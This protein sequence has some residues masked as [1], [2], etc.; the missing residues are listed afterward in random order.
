MNEFF[1]AFLITPVWSF[2]KNISLQWQEEDML[3]FQQ[4]EQHNG[5]F[6]SHDRKFWL[7]KQLTGIWRA[8]YAM[9]M[10]QRELSLCISIPQVLQNYNLL[11]GLQKLFPVMGL[12]LKKLCFLPKSLLPIIHMCSP[13]LNLSSRHMFLCSY[14]LAMTN[15]FWILYFIAYNVREQAHFNWKMHHFSFLFSHSFAI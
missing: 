10:F 14:I 5:T 4:T 7:S 13:W 9:E 1:L 15:M 8:C 11:F 3:I 12:Q 6:C 2:L